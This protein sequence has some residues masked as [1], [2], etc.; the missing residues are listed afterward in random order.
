MLHQRPQFTTYKS[1][2]GQAS[3]HCSDVR[4]HE[5]RGYNRKRHIHDLLCCEYM[6]HISTTQAVTYSMK[7]VGIIAARP[8]QATAVRAAMTGAVSMQR[9]H[10]KPSPQCNGG[11]ASCYDWRSAHMLC[12]SVNDSRVDSAMALTQHGMS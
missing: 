11:C 2:K 6:L 5:H 4:F 7:P 12:L 1:S 10:T 9:T 8:V 3:H